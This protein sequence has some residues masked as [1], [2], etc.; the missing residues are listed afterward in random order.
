LRQNLTKQCNSEV[1]MKTRFMTAAM[2][3][4]LT[5]ACS[6]VFAADSKSDRNE[7]AANSL[8]S[9]PRQDDGQS[10]AAVKSPT[11]EVKAGQAAPTTAQPTQPDVTAIAIQ[12]APQTGEQINWQAMSGGGGRGA[13]SGYVLTGTVGQT[14]VGP[15]ASTGYKL[16]QGFWQNFVVS[17]CVGRTGNV[18]GDPEDIVDISDLSAMVDYLF[19]SLPIS[20]CPAENDVDTSGSVDISDLTVLVDFLF[21]GATLPS[22]P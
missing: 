1:Q 22:C 16:N 4:I 21:F 9:S 12:N 5:V 15:V 14:A 11:T 13:S 19:F 6:V 3:L 18:D 20:A 8:K 2:A 17:C 10:P 7:R